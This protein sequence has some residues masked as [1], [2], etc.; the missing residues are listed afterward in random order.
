[1]I[2]GAL[3]LSGYDGPWELPEDLRQNKAQL[4]YTAKSGDRVSRY[5]LSIYDSEWNA[6]DQVPERAVASGLIGSLG[7]I[8]PSLGRIT[9]RIGLSANLQGP[10]WEG[11]VY[12][13]DYDFAL[14]SNFT[15]LLNDPLRGDE[16][17]QRDQRRIYCEHWEQTATHSVGGRDVNWRWGASVRFDDIGKVGLFQTQD[18]VRFATLRDDSVSEWSA[19]AFTEMDLN[20]TDRLRAGLGLRA[21]YLNWDVNAVLPQNSGSGGE[22]QISPKLRLAY[23]LDETMESYFTYG[24]GMHSI[25]VRGTTISV[26]PAAGGFRDQVLKRHIVRKVKSS[27]ANFDSLSRQLAVFS[28]EKKKKAT[29]IQEKTNVAA[30]HRVLSVPDER[31]ER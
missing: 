15:Y 1:M 27:R 31:L 25:D 17:E 19:G 12:A 2:T 26:D 5:R 8:D 28:S 24:R 6:T 20:I 22:T 18:R 29:A 10:N 23:R 4:Y 11:G 30:N 14:F 3:D 21:D 13:I 9:R 16:F 7:F